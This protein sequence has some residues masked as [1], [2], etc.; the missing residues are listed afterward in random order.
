MQIITIVDYGMG[1]IKSIATAINSITTKTGL[2]ISNI[3]EEIISSDK[4]IL[5]G[6]GHFGNACNNLDNLELRKVIEFVVKEKKTPILGICLGMQLLFKNSEEAS[7]EDSGLGFF[8]ESVKRLKP[9]TERV[10]HV[11]FNEVKASKHSKM[12]NDLESRDFYF[13]HN[14][15]ILDE[16]KKGIVSTTQ[17]NSPVV[18]SIEYDNIWGTQFHPE[19]SQRNGLKLIDNFLKI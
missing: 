10:P 14:Y 1:N 6:V 19:K 7:P 17:H 9:G 13:V 3:P 18:A 5:P 2:K 4:I 8:E 11:G 16:P 12:F 15:G